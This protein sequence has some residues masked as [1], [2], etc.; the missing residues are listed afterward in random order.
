MLN[1]DTDLKGIVKQ[2]FVLAIFDSANYNYF[3]K[4]Y[5]QLEKMLDTAMEQKIA[6]MKD[7]DIQ[8]FGLAVIDGND[9]G[10]NAESEDFYIY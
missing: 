5:E 1:K 3:R 4:D 9:I 8:T 6:G 10:Y 7:E 2:N